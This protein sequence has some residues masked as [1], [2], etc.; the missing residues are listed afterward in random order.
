ML[1]VSRPGG[2][3]WVT[4]PDD[5]GLHGRPRLEPPGL[6]PE[7][8]DVEQKTPV[9]LISAVP[10]VVV[11]SENMKTWG[12]GWGDVTLVTMESRADCLL[13]ALLLTTGNYW[14]VCLFGCLHARCS[15]LSTKM[16]CPMCCMADIPGVLGRR[17]RREGTTREINIR[18][19][20][21]Q[22]YRGPRSDNWDNSH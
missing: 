19:T 6:E 17:G 14:L 4:V 11:P 15:N 18:L 8:E 13:S 2:Q 22:C 16:V 7:Q 5:H 21:P 1:H 20:D 12:Q 9:Y 10:L 3:L